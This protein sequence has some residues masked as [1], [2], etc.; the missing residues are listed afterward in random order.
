MI[1]LTEMLDKNNNDELKRAS[2]YGVGG[3]ILGRVPAVL[4]TSF[5]KKK[6]NK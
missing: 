3:L 2:L 5:N 6:K 4:S 1:L